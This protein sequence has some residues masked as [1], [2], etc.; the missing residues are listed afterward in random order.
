MAVFNGTETEDTYE[1]TSEGDNVAGL[2]GNDT[3]VGN[4][5]RDSLDGGSDNDL[6][7]AGNGMLSAST[8]FTVVAGDFGGSTAGVSDTLFGGQGND[9][10]VGAQVG[11]SSDLLIGNAGLDLLVA[12]VNGGSIAI[13]GQGDDTIYGS[14]QNGNVMNGSSGDD[15]LLSGLGN[16]TLLGDRGSDILVGGIGNND[17]YGGDG[18]DEFQLLSRK[19]NT[20]SVFTSTDRILRSDGGFGGIDTIYDF[21]SDDRITIRDLDRNALVT[22]TTNAVGA[23]VITILGTAGNGQPADQLI[24]VLGI[25]REQL[26]TPGAGLIAVNNNFINI[27]NTFSTDVVS[28]F[29]V[30]NT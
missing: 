27:T 7:V 3:L 29:T 22:V 24:T 30:V 12:A 11:F 14:L 8:N 17:M 19:D 6:L 26:L 28:T 13:G 25:T 4:A 18:S 23:A 2:G 9:T 21:G 16:D 10:L 5:G 20:L 1:A 15:L